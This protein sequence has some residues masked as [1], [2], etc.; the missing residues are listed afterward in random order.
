MR[1]LR[2]V[3]FLGVSV[4]LG[5]G[6]PA[7]LPA[8][9]IHVP[10]P[11]GGIYTVQDGIDAAVDGDLVLVAPGTYVGLVNFGGKAITVR[12]T[13]GP[14]ATILESSE[15]NQVVSFTSGEG[16]QS[17]L[18]GFTIQKA[19][20][21]W[22]SG[23][24]IAGASPVI[25]EN[26]IQQNTYP[27]TGGGIHVTGGSP[28]IRHNTIRNNAV[29][30]FG[31]GGITLGGGGIFLSGSGAAQITNNFIQGNTQGCSV[32]FCVGG[33]GAGIYVTGGSHRIIGNVISGNRTGPMWRQFGAG[34]H[35]SATDGAVV[36]S[37][38]I[39]GNRHTPTSET[40]E[41]G[42]AG[43]FVAPDNVNLL[44]A[45]NIVQENV[46]QGVLC[47]EGAG[48]DIR[49][50]AYFGNPD[51]DIVDCPAGAGDLFV[52][53]GMADPAAGDFRLTG[54]SPVVDM[55]TPGIAGTPALDV[56]LEPRLADGNGDG[57]AVIDIGADEFH[58]P[59]PEPW[60]A[61]EAQAAAAGTGGTAGTGTPAGTLFF[62]L[63]PALVVLL[64]KT[65][66][67]PDPRARSV[68]GG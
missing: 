63:V 2:V 4:A 60:G 13:S 58:P 54:M 12:S 15:G 67:S 45:N 52:D 43:L 34:V 10:D 25:E 24:R 59:P 40:E 20:L 18:R 1:I 8:A 9:E 46:G 66:R 23:I 32:G 68:S 38:T 31:A 62:L 64:W 17:V 30:G 3:T 22:G 44:L 16:N 39:H 19:G 50:N 6:V 29:T 11:A 57:S 42:G 41:L 51:G 47:W 14:G 7:A 21:L 48:V 5:F 37:N 65:L 28:V 49:T 61:A 56:Y 55:G 36:A 26:I 33:Y 53:A 27:F 35:I